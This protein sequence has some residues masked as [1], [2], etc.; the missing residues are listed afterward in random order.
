MIVIFGS[1]NADLIFELDVAPAPG[2]TLLAKRFRM[3][4]GGKGA[5]Q[6]VAAAR[7][8]AEAAMVGAVGADPL[9]HVAVGQLAGCGVDM[10]RIRT[11]TLDTGCASILVDAQGRN[12]IAVALGA[13][14]EAAADQVDD[15]LL[16]RADW[17]LL[18]MESRPA[19][20]AAL[21][22]RAHAA[23]VRTILNLAPAI[24]LDAAVLRLCS[25]LV[26]NESE[27]RSV[28]GWLGC[29]DGARALHEAL[30]IDVLRTLGERGAEA[31][32]ADGDCFVP[33]HPIAAVDTTAAGD[34]FV[35]VLAAALDRGDTL[36]HAMQRASKAA[37]LACTRSG[38]QSSL[39]WKADIDAWVPATDA[40]V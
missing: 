7:D 9:Q 19:E 30:G 40:T 34:C 3:E 11:A 23:G 26:V 38:S 29:G 28:A 2:E 32:T 39:P 20:V 15:E 27:A 25:L 13:N 24:R 14:G 33:A 5:N 6:A 4:A 17:L 22:V 31:A 21:L 18:Q 36:R 1:L 10:S 37:A 12:Q 8:G 35:G 16:G